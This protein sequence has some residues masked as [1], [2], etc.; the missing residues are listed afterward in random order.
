MET[1]FVKEYEQARKWYVI[2]AA[3]KPMGRVAAKAAAIARGKNKPTY[4]KNQ[5]MG[6]Y[7]VIINAEKAAVTGGKETKKLYH[8]YT[9]YAGGLVTQTYAKL[10]EK[11]PTDPM[12]LA[13]AGMLPHNRLGRKMM[14]NVKIY[15]GAEHPHA[16]HN[17]QPIEL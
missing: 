7:V 9:G 3:G 17:P 16:A 11:H 10:S 14:D 15:A 4:T 12:K 5:L 8:H 1:I 13:V 6:D 2:D